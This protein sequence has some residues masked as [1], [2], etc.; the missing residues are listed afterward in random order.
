[1]PLEPECP[2]LAHHDHDRALAGRD[3]LSVVPIGFT[4]TLMECPWIE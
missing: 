2:P 3:L 1:V 4:Q